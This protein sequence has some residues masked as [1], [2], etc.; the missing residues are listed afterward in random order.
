MAFLSAVDPSSRIILESLEGRLADY[1]A[2]P[3]YHDEWIKGLNASW[4]EESHRAQVAMCDLIAPNSSVLEVG[5]GDGAAALEILQRTRG[6]NYTGIDL[7]AHAW[8]DRFGGS[9]SGSRRRF[10]IGSATR[11]PFEA[12]TFDVVLSMFV[13]EHLVF[14]HEFLSG[15]WRVLRPNGRL[16]VI[17]PDFSCN[18]M[19]SERIGTSYGS[20]RDKLRR[21]RWWDAATT[22]WD[23]RVRIARQRRVR[24]R[25]LRHGDTWFPILTEPRCFKLPGFVP[26]SDA[27][28]P[29]CPEEIT[30]YFEGRSDLAN[31]VLFYRDSNLFGLC[32]RKR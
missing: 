4:C 20:G 23:T 18:A 5:C 32:I 25:R 14:P 21:G 12:T 1:Y 16:I 3:A 11:L 9:A 27:V 13:L 15:A 28:Y 24:R 19:A 30:N 22:W 6:A 10:E 8:R 17:A 2:K 29:S 7:N 31:W 26:D